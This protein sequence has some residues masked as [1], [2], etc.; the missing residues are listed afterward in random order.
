MSANTPPPGLDD[1][2][3]NK[4]EIHA[5]EAHRNTFPAGAQLQ[6]AATHTC[7]KCPLCNTD[8]EKSL[9]YCSHCA[10]THELSIADVAELANFSP[11]DAAR[12]SAFLVRRCEL[13]NATMAE[14][15][16]QLIRIGTDDKVDNITAT[17]YGALMTELKE[18]KCEPLSHRFWTQYLIPNLNAAIRLHP[19]PPLSSST[20]FLDQTS[21]N[22]PTTP[23]RS[24]SASSHSSDS[25]LTLPRGAAAPQV[26]AGT[27]PAMQRDHM[28]PARTQ[29]LAVAKDGT[30]LSQVKSGSLSLSLCIPGDLPSSPQNAA[31][32]VSLRRHLIVLLLQTCATRTLS[33]S[34]AADFKQQLLSLQKNRWATVSIFPHSDDAACANSSPHSHIHVKMNNAEA[35]VATRQLFEHF[36]ELGVTLSNVPAAVEHRAARAEEREPAVEGFV[37]IPADLTAAEIE[38][39]W[40]PLLRDLPSIYYARRNTYAGS[41]VEKNSVHW[42]LPASKVPLLGIISK[43][44]IQRQGRPITFDCQWRKLIVTSPSSSI[45]CTGC[46]TVGAG[47]T[48]RQCPAG[49]MGLCP[50]CKG[51]HALT[52]CDAERGSDASCLLCHEQH[53]STE[54]PLIK[55]KREAE[56]FVPAAAVISVNPSTAEVARSEQAAPTQLL[57]LVQAQPVSFSL[58]PTTYAAAAAMVHTPPRSKQQQQLRP[59]PA[60][61]SRPAVAAAATLTLPPSNSSLSWDGSTIMSLFHTQTQLLQVLVS[62]NEASRKTQDLILEMVQSE[63]RQRAADRQSLQQEEPSREAHPSGE[64]GSSTS[65]TPRA[66][67]VATEPAAAPTTSRS[68]PRSIAQNTSASN[69]PSSRPQ[70]Q[71]T[72]KTPHDA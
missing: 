2:D 17:I 53:I 47:H 24:D 63:R 60:R 41:G 22:L 56:Q 46:W 43:L 45:P 72:R 65:D 6:T 49:S 33:P 27:I 44:V 18:L 35:A 9:I 58:Q 55:R 11:S 40:E 20:T 14:L 7:W 54:C 30:H 38:Q 69:P 50:R 1:G 70:R 51:A 29:A 26:A 13:K 15:C 71:I 25:A 68:R 5:Q 19:N 32:T 12:T 57:Q 23:R 48:R 59:S 8:N 28:H 10:H 16:A 66:A 4:E 42:K 61:T 37:S 31:S 52:R 34:Q 21:A 62:Q 3:D 39:W 64:V 67:V 36:S